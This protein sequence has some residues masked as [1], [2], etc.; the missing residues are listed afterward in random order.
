MVINI[1]INKT[2]PSEFNRNNI[3]GF[4]EKHNKKQKTQLKIKKHK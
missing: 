2:C 1:S 3:N 4:D